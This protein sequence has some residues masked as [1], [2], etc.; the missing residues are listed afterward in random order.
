[1]RIL[2][3]ALLLLFTV[4]IIALT[5]PSAD[6]RSRDV[7]EAWGC[8]FA[9]GTPQ[10]AARKRAPDGSLLGPRIWANAYAQCERK[11]WFELAVLRLYRARP[12]G[13]DE[14]VAVDRRPELGATEAWIWELEVVTRCRA[15]WTND[16][17]PLYARA[18]FTKR[19]QSERVFVTSPVW[20]S[21][22]DR[23]CPDHGRSDAG[24]SG[25]RP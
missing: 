19:G 20:D 17:P 11:T 22:G 14:V 2:T 25:Q 23:T 12:G 4:S 3:T 8:V 21:D 13:K 5:P 10:F 1:M 16:D 9:V 24:V 18:V 15:G 6:A 7:A